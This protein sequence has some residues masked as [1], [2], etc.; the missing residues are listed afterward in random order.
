MN[1]EV[2]VK[3]WE[4]KSTFTD[5]DVEG[6]IRAWRKDELNESDWTQL[7]DVLNSSNLKWEWAVYRQQLRE[8][9]DSG[10]PVKDIVFPVRPA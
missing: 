2:L 9:F 10:K 7:P 3:P 1:W 8:M 4:D 5:T 6:R